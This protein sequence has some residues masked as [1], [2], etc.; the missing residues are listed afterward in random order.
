MAEQ[1]RSKESGTPADHVW[2]LPRISLA[3]FGWVLVCLATGLALLGAA[4][5]SLNTLIVAETI[6]L[7]AVGVTVL[8]AVGLISL[9]RSRPSSRSEG[10]GARAEAIQFAAAALALIAAVVTLLGSSLSQGDDGSNPNGLDPST[11]CVP[12]AKPG[13]E[14]GKP[15]GAK[16]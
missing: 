13:P 10:S 1:N 16:S 7:S 5:G 11:P 15:A 9:I 6:V 14:Y 4:T 2:R 8:L 12:Q 3:V